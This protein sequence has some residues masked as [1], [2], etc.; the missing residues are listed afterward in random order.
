ML[1]KKQNNHL[2]KIVDLLSQGECISGNRIA[3]LL[4]LSRSA[5]W[6]AIKKLQLYNI[7]I[8]SKKNGYLLNSKLKLLDIDV[9]SLSLQNRPQINLEI[10][11]SIN[12]TNQYYL[13]NILDRSKTHVCLAEFQSNGQ[14]RLGRNWLSP[15]GQNIYLSICTLI[16]IDLSNLGGLSLAISLAVAKALREATHNDE[17]KVKWPNDVIY[18]KQK[19]AGTLIQIVAEQNGLCKI[20]IGVGVNVNA[21]K[22]NSSY[23]DITQNWSSLKEITAKATDRNILAAK[24]I[25]DILDCLEKFKNNG[26][27]TFIP[28]W[29]KIDYFFGQEISLHSNE[30]IITGIENG[31]DKNGQLLLTVN[32]VTKS[33]SSGET[34]FVKS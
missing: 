24:L 11:E 4:G 31:V 23:H 13:D 3:Q 2:V 12:S 29:N 18:N 10:F 9:I 8:T 16:A 19:L 17:I 22:K 7:P 14:G 33:Y 25:G 34:S 5:V 30:K 15:F 21:D 1:Q 27:E 20:V 28:E 32:Q 6:K 26:F